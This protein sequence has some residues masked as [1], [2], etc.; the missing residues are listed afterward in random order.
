MIKKESRA[1]RRKR[2]HRR[3]R[4]V[5]TGTAKR[6]RLSIFR[7]EKHIYAQLIDDAHSSTLASASSVSSELKGGKKKS[8]KKTGSPIEL[9]KTVGT[10]VAKRA[11]E[12][13]IKEIVFDR[14]G[15]KF[16]GRV[17]ALADGAREGGLVF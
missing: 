13:G 8:S 14:G 17:K 10:L 11:V 7:S 16:H 15:T 12:K 3:S 9:A 1:D 2:R 4:S 6:P 5:L